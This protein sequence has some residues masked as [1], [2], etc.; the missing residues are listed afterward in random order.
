MTSGHLA[1]GERPAV[2]LVRTF[3]DPPAEVWGALTERDRL[4]AWFPCEIDVDGGEWVAGAALTFTF[5]A[6]VMELTLA[7]EVLVADEPRALAF[8]WGDEVLRFE[9][10]DEGSGTRLV[11]T[12]ELPASFAARNASG[13]EDCL[14]RLGGTTPVAGSW[15]V[16][17]DE[18]V[19]AFEPTLGHQDGPPA[20]YHGDL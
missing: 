9:L 14:D 1:A 7:G 11:L 5:P 12:N 2:Q 17:F 4:Q 8:T 18:Y 13:W 19:A 16:H 3:P 15:R 20:E 10:S 6:H